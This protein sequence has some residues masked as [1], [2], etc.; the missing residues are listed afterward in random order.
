MTVRAFLLSG[1][2]AVAGLFGSASRADAQ[3]VFG[4]GYPYGGVYPATSFVTPYGGYASPYLGGYASPY[5]GGYT[6]PYWS[7]RYYNYQTPY[8]TR[9]GSYY[10][11]NPGYGPGT[12]TYRWGRWGY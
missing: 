12:Y 9:Y 6:A 3:V 11:A 1:L 10:Y 7:G 2:L 8:G 5:W 4:Y